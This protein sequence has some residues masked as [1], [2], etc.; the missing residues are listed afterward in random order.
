MQILLAKYN[1]E[2]LE[3]LLVNMILDW[4]TKSNVLRRR[5]F[6]AMSMIH[7]KTE[8]HALIGGRL[9]AIVLRENIITNLATGGGDECDDGSTVDLIDDLLDIWWED[10]QK[11]KDLK[12]VDSMKHRSF[13]FDFCR[14][15]HTVNDCFLFVH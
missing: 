9:N 12:A 6:Q 11:V 7:T 14:L 4:Q 2:E 13:K 8:L 5:T 15:S 1:L 3:E 10:W